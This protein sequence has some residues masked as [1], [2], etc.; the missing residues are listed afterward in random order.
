MPPLFTAAP[1]PFHR[2]LLGRLASTLRDWYNA[3]ARWF[4]HSGNDMPRRLRSIYA[5]Q[6]ALLAQLQPL[7]PDTD[8]RP[9]AFTADPWHAENVIY[10]IVSME[11]SGSDKIYVGQTSQ[12]LFQRF[13]Q[14]VQAAAYKRIRARSDYLYH[15]YRRIPGAS[16]HMTMGPADPTEFAIIPLQAVPAP[17]PGS[18]FRTDA[19]TYETMWILHLDAYKPRGY[20]QCWPC[21]P[22]SLDLQHPTWHLQQQLYRA[23]VEATGQRRP[24]PALSDVSDDLPC[25]ACGNTDEPDSLLLCDGCNSGCHAACCRPPAVFDLVTP[26]FCPTCEV[27]GVAAQ[28]RNNA[29]L[30]HR[31]G[32]AAYVHAPPAAQPLGAAGAAGAAAATPAAAGAAATLSSDDDALP[33]PS[34]P[35]S[36]DEP[37]DSPASSSPSSTA[38]GIPRRPRR[39]GTRDLPRRVHALAAMV[40]AGQLSATDFSALGQ[41]NLSRV[42]KLISFLKQ[43]SAPSLGLT[44]ATHQTVATALTN[45]YLQHSP[46][47][48]H[49]SQNRGLAIASFLS[50]LITRLRLDKIMNDPALVQYLPPAT[51]PLKPPIVCYKYAKTLGRKWFNFQQVAGLPVAVQ[52]A[53]CAAPCICGQHPAL[54]PAGHSHI[55]T[56]DIS[57]LVSSGNI[58]ELWAL[59]TKYR[60]CSLDG[61]NMNDGL[62]QELHQTFRHALATFASNTEDDLAQPGAMGPWL[63]EAVYAVTTAIDNIPNGSALRHADLLA[64]CPFRVV[65]LDLPLSVQQLLFLQSHFVITYMDKAAN[66]FVLVCKK[67]YIQAL[68]ADLTTPP[69]APQPPFYIPLSL[70]AL[71]PRHSHI[72]DELVRLELVEPPPRTRAELAAAA[73]APSTGKSKRGKPAPRPTYPFYAGISKQH[74]TPVAFRYLACSSSIHLTPA[75]LKLNAFFRALMPSVYTLW[76]KAAAKVNTRVLCSVPSAACRSWDGAPWLA[77]NSVEAAAVAEHFNR[78]G[79]TTP[80]SEFNL[81]TYDFARLYTN[82]DQDRLIANVMDVVTWAFRDNGRAGQPAFA[83]RAYMSKGLQ[84]KWFHGRTY[85]AVTDA[86]G[87][88]FYTFTLDA[89][90]DMLTLVIKNTFIM[91]G[92]DNYYHQVLGIP[93]G[94][95]PAVFIAN[96]YLFW[97]EYTFVARLNTLFSSSGPTDLFPYQE[98]PLDSPLLDPATSPLL[99]AGATTTRQVVAAV[100]GAFAFTK[101]FVDDLLAVDN[102]LLPYLTYCSQ[103]LGPI[104]GIY[105]SGLQLEP[106]VPVRPGLHPVPYLDLEFLPSAT[107]TGALKLNIRLYDKRQSDKFRHLNISRFPHATSSLSTAAKV[108]I[109]T[110]R[111]VH[112]CRVITVREDFCWQLARVMFD[113]AGRGYKMPKLW[114]KLQHCLRRRHAPWRCPWWALLQHIRADYAY[115]L[116]VGSAQPPPPPPPR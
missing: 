108:N 33:P 35:P 60:P 92:K 75:A 88:K 70:D 99:R 76:S 77:A 48:T 101:R 53:V 13:R 109:V 113:F 64:A 100:L 63:S 103:R 51:P 3:T 65:D 61:S 36:D 11:R 98:L 82:I 89:V 57:A 26:W 68:R 43:H 42:Y 83:L 95:N 17:P 16:L 78:H 19:N 49:G 37:P 97:Y 40:E 47:A 69:P 41:R 39:F 38:P 10:A 59:G 54:I 79:C 112:F 7:I 55:V 15:H 114:A 44:V 22:R 84:P 74:K 71:K 105:D 110:S 102:P 23:Y 85:S 2:F 12:P 116:H 25:L 80:A 4:S 29:D 87:E 96:L 111:Y 67:A 8:L 34:P 32:R 115:M 106:S 14:H 21:S 94:I 9:R 73:A 27:S 66:N 24:P 6:D 58:Q 30:D 1:L 31:G 20:N 18:T 46:T 90:R 86:T 28:L 107:S 104:T 45:Y 62:R 50:P 5:K 56:T 72:A 81:S 52:D 93:M 91:F